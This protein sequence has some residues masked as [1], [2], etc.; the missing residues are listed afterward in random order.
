ME[1]NSDGSNRSSS[2]TGISARSYSLA[3][4]ISGLHSSGL[5]LMVIARQGIDADLFQM[6]NGLN[7]AAR[8]PTV[9]ATAVSVAAGQTT[10]RLGGSLLSGTSYSVTVQTQPTEETCT[11]AGGSGT[12]Q[13]ANVANVVVTCSGEAY[14]LAGSISGLYGAVWCWQTAPMRLP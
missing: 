6:V 8:A 4:T 9:N 10:Q 3:A 14:S 11:V 5:V 7:T 12:I 13:S 2:S 1:S